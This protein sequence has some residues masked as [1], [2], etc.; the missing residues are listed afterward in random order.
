MAS[1]GTSL[2]PLE[3]EGQALL[4]A[5]Q[6]V[7]ALGYKNVIF[8]GDCLVLMRSIYAEHGDFSIATI[9]NDIRSWGSRLEKVQFTHVHREANGVAHILAT[10]CNADVLFTSSS[11]L[12]PH[13]LSNVI[14]NDY[15][16]CT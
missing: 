8:E 3:A 14:C 16:R 10:K 4:A 6:C 2:S 5:I 7:F 11:T 1:L 15:I 9:C 12:I 13:W